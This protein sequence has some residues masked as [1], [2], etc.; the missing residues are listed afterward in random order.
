[1][2][3]EC[4]YW[5]VSDVVSVPVSDSLTAVAAGQKLSW[6]LRFRGNP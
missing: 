3:L 1:M 6:C 5:L 4:L 2:W